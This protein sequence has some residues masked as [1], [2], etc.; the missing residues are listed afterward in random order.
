MHKKY[1]SLIL[2]VC[3]TRLHVEH[4]TTRTSMMKIYHNQNRYVLCVFLRT[5]HVF[6]VC[7]TSSIAAL[8]LAKKVIRN[9]KCFVSL[10]LSVCVLRRVHEC[11]F[12]LSAREELCFVRK[13]LW[14]TIYPP[15]SFLLRGSFMVRTVR[16]R[17]NSVS[18]ASCVLK[19]A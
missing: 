11:F 14:K 16:F 13:M 4:S 7:Q 1:L 6:D 17:S 18:F 2:V 15:P 3:H 5:G 19:D 10:S 9:Q 8:S 12:F